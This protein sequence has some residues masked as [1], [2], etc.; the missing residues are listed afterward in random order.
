MEMAS[1]PAIT[2][3]M[4]LITS[5]RSSMSLRI[6]LDISMALLER[7]RMKVSSDCPSSI[8]RYTSSISSDTRIIVLVSS[9]REL[10][11]STAPC[12]VLVPKITSV[13]LA[14]FRE[15]SRILSVSCCMVRSRE[16]ICI[17]ARIFFLRTSENCSLPF[18]S[19]R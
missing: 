9:S 3:F 15:I 7:S 11:P 17:T 4:L 1:I 14:T 6:S 5:S 16:L 12:S 13:A 8:F 18:T 19:R 10:C 2:S